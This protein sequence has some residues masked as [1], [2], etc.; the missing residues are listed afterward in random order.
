MRIE[1]IEASP[2]DESRLANLT[3]LYVHD[4]S[5]ILEMAPGDDGRF[6]YR[7]SEYWTD[8]DRFPFLIRADGSL[9]GFALIGR[10]SVV[11]EDPEVMDVAEFFVVRGLRRRGVGLA[12]AHQVF[13]RFAGPWEVRVMERNAPA[14]PFWERT[15]STFSGG[16]FKSGPHTAGS[17]NRFLV[18]QFSSAGS[19]PPVID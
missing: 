15:V 19:G 17:D 10:G 13:S 18:F 5:E 12:A 6:G 7:L 1:L 8:S 3:E 2:S 9:A 16:S 11:T 4:F 14:I